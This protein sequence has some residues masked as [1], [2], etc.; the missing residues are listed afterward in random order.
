M[1]TKQLL[2]FVLQI[3]FGGRHMHWP[4]LYMSTQAHALACTCVHVLPA[5]SDSVSCQVACKPD[6]I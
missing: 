5:V 2:S 3:G 1:P 4:V 6:R